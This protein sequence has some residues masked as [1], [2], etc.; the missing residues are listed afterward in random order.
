[1]THHLTFVHET[2][3]SFDSL[4]IFVNSCDSLSSP[5][6]APTAK[7]QTANL[8][9]VFRACPYEMPLCAPCSLRVHGFL[10]Y[11][12]LNQPEFNK[13]L[14]NDSPVCTPRL[15]RVSACRN[16][17]TRSKAQTRQDDGLKAKSVQSRP[18]VR[19]CPRL[20][21]RLMVSDRPES[22]GGPLTGVLHSVPAEANSAVV[23]DEKKNSWWSAR[24]GRGKR[25][26]SRFNHQLPGEL[27]RQTK[28]NRRL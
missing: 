4:S 18:S 2:E 12:V 25:D 5:V 7:F 6:R 17:E 11:L 24:C 8:G 22:R 23:K 10:G 21:L 14:Q 15:R 9:L 28:P 1:M 13:S 27:D 16:H 26:I 3:R 20:P 19:D